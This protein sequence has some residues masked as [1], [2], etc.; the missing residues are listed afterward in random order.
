MR[1]E[2]QRGRPAGWSEKREEPGDA[3]YKA[4]QCSFGGEK[5]PESKRRGWAKKKC[6]FRRLKWGFQAVAMRRMSSEGTSSAVM[7]LLPIWNRVDALMNRFAGAVQ[8]DR[9]RIA[10]RSP[11]LKSKGAVGSPVGASL[12]LRLWL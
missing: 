2:W 11:S 6:H 9:G 8:S 4:F 3:L 7:V 5:K 12:S 1:P 10:V